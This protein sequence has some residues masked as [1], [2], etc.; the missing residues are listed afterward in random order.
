[1]KFPVPEPSEQPE[2]PIAFFFEDVSFDLPDE[3]GLRAW[4]L[5]VAEA[6]GKSV[7]E[8]N[9]IFCSDEHL[10]GINVE[11]LDHDYYTDIITFDNSDD[12]RMQGEIYIS[13]ERVAEN[14]QTNGVPFHHELCRV[15]VHGVL[16][17]AGY[18][19]KTPEHEAI[20]RGKE[21]F[22]LALLS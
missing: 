8:I 9:Y 1:M 14:A 17:M 12:A 16:H 6:E 7:W 4:L 3:S 18:G 2:E 13:S 21:D 10:R 19:D 5:S 15:M 11:F 22:Y 20:M